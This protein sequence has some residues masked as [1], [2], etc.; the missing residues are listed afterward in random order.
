MKDPVVALHCA[1]LASKGQERDDF[2]ISAQRRLLHKY[3][4]TNSSG[5]WE[6]SM[7]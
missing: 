1:R 6:H 3:A 5:A 7:P 4:S 2:S